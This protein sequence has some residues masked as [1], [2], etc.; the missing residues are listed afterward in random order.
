MK[1]H[2]KDYFREKQSEDNA[3]LRRAANAINLPEFLISQRFHATKESSKDDW[4]VKNSPLGK[5]RL[6]FRDVWLC[7]IDNE[8]PF[9]AVQLV[10]RLYDLNNIKA[11]KFILGISASSPSIKDNSAAV[12]K[13]QEKQNK[14]LPELPEPSAAHIDAGVEYLARRGIDQ[15]TF[16]MLRSAGNAEYVN[17]GLCFIG[18]NSNGAPKLMETRY[19]VDQTDNNNPGK[20]TKHSVTGGSQRKYAVV[21]PGTNPKLIEIVEGNFDGM[22][23]FEMN[24]RLLPANDQPTII[25][26]GGKDTPKFLENPDIVELLKNAESIKC[27]GD[28]EVLDKAD[29]DDDYEWAEAKYKKQLKTDDAHQ[30]RIEQIKLICPLSTAEYHKP[31]VGHHDLAEL[32]KKLK[33]VLAKAALS[34]PIPVKKF[35]F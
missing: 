1:R 10:E 22:A 28:N 24:K 30:K 7:H 17:N 19:I 26:S 5:I 2:T 21:I 9:N 4:V 12:E 34:K 15:S 23:L 25:I 16:E 13:A 33:E 3:K 20:S 14:D 35:N 31:P 11:A 29:F 32:N 6:S 18:R 27:Y 8:T